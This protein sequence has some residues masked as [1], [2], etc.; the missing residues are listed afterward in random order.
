MCIRDRQNTLLPQVD[1]CLMS[2]CSGGIIANSSFSWWGA[3]LQG[4]RGKIIAPDPEKWYG[5]AMTHLDTS[6]MV[7]ARWQIHYW[8]K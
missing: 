1:L 8:S 2:L 4:D 6:M 7:P 3:W 5:S